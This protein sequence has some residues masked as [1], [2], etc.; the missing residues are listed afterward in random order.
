MTS[1]LFQSGKA[2]FSSSSSSS[3]SSSATNPFQ[4]LAHFYEQE[5]SDLQVDSG[6]QQ[7]HPASEKQKSTNHL[8]PSSHSSYTRKD[9]ASSSASHYRQQQDDYRIFS[10][11]P[12]TTHWNPHTRSHLHISSPAGGGEG[13]ADIAEYLKQRQDYYARE[14]RLRS[15]DRHDGLGPIHDFSEPHSHGHS[16]YHHHHPHLASSRLEEQLSEWTL[17]QSQLQHHRGARGSSQLEQVWMD[18]G[19]DSLPDYNSG[20]TNWS[21][22]MESAWSKSSEHTTLSPG[23]RPVTLPI[24][25]GASNFHEAA[26]S[27]HAPWPMAAWAIEAEAALMEV[28]TIHHQHAIIADYGTRANPSTEMHQQWEAQTATAG[29][30]ESTWIQEFILAD[31]AQEAKVFNSS[32][33]RKEIVSVGQNKSSNRRGSVVKTCGF[34]FESKNHQ[35]A[36]DPT[37]LDLG[38]LDFKA[39]DSHF[40]SDDNHSATS[41]LPLSPLALEKQSTSH[42][43]IGYDPTHPQPDTKPNIMD[44]SVSA[45]ERP[46]QVFNDELF[47]GDMLQAWMETLAQEKQKADERVQE[48]EDLKEIVT[49]RSAE[50]ETKDRLVLEVAL[51]RLNILMHQLGRTQ[52]SFSTP[53]GNTGPGSKSK[54]APISSQPPVRDYVPSYFQ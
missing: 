22:N 3:S 9:N 30:R 29:P 14:A 26:A 1:L 28:E 49:V 10:Q 48:T 13:Q 36:S 38:E 44:I 8:F 33:L 54:V 42:P 19:P 24:P 6:L 39:T 27:L 16:D 17:D 34:M 31:S 5:L 50:E 51:R 18:L 20:D 46:G 4:A 23:T 47:E 21:R 40:P 7:Q 2:T 15:Q 45:K 52:R 25:S 37:L 11:G 41:I 12:T 43:F 35:D 32:D 53:N